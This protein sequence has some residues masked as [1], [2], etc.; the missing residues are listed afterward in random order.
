MCR[1]F[2]VSAKYVSKLDLLKAYLQ[3]PLTDL[4]SEIAVF[5]TPDHFLQYTV[6]ALGMCNTPATFQ[7]FLNTV[8]I[9]LPDCNAYLD[10]LRIYTNTWEENMQVLEQVPAQ[11]AQASLTL[12]LAKFDF[13]KATVT[14]LGRQVGQGQ[15]CPVDAKVSATMDCPIPSTRRTLHQ[16]LGMAGYYR[17][18][19]FVGIF[20]LLF[21]L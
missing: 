3:V 11:F 9:G 2:R 7:M 12:N 1:L 8:L 4:A 5:V 14:C 18:F 19:F 10:D 16:F 15:V 20:T 21:T 13:G 6:M 17:S